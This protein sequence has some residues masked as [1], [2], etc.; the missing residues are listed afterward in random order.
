M[1][2]GGIDVAHD[3]HFESE[4]NLM[5][6]Q[7]RQVNWRCI[8]MDAQYLPGVQDTGYRALL[9]QAIPLQPQA[10]QEM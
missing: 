8:C 9:G 2:A 10:A 3:G 7:T 4:E 1:D 5:L 6:P